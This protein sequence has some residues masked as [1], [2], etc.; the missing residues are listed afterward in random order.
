M[1]LIKT[2]QEILDYVPIDRTIDFPRLKPYVE[3]A[4]EN[5]INEALGADQL[6]ELE[7]QYESDTLTSDNQKLLKQCQRVIACMAV[8]EFMDFNQIEVSDAGNQ[9]QTDDNHKTAFQ[10]Q[11][12]T[13]QGSLRQ[14]GMIALDN[15]LAT[16][17][18]FLDLY[19]LWRDSE[20]ATIQLQHLI[21]NT[22][23]FD[24][25][26][27]IGKSRSMFLALMPLMKKVEWMY[28]R[29]H[30]GEAL[31]DEIKNEILTRSV[32][33]DNQSLLEN[34]LI[35]ATAHLTVFKAMI[36]LSLKVSDRG[37]LI[38]EIMN[39]G[40]NVRKE[41]AANT[42]LM[43]G[44]MD[45][46]ET[47]GRYYLEEAKKYLNVN[48]SDTKYNAFFS[49]SLYQGTTKTPFQNHKTKIFFA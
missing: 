43:Q 11:K 44:L 38:H 41:S 6:A 40:D 23:D 35:P 2:T 24:M 13:S 48:A 20:A 26:V 39:S 47:E 9:I 16:L 28:I 49:S 31:Y 10:W 32:S 7:T 37:V 25:Q 19:P 3:E 1:T 30:I 42:Q 12:D 45:Q 22:T 29:E 33:A 8:P 14:R 21:T 34:Y 18:N 4:Q 17:E 46:Y 36:P 5:W 15:M 27:R